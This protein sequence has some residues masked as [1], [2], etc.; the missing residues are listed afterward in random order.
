MA[1]PSPMRA[2]TIAK[3]SLPGFFALPSISSSDWSSVESPEDGPIGEVIDK[4]SGCVDC[5][6]K[7]G[8]ETTGH[9]EVCCWAMSDCWWCAST[10]FGIDW[11]V[12]PCLLLVL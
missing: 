12:M 6:V 10:L 1:Q 3:R 5:S 11:D 7:E 8:G 4:S 2:K 9:E